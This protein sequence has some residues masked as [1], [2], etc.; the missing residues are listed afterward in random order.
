M[1]HLWGNPKYRYGTYI[2]TIAQLQLNQETKELLSDSLFRFIKN[3]E[4]KNNSTAADYDKKLRRMEIGQGL[5]GEKLKAAFEKMEPE[6][7]N[8]A[9]YYLL[10]L[11][12]EK[13]SITLYGKALIS[14][15]GDGVLYK[16]RR[17]K[18]SLLLYMGREENMTDKAVFAFAGEAFLP[19][20]Y[21]VD[22]YWETSFGVIGEEA[23]MELEAILLY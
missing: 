1:E 5:Y 17:K 20:G 6:Q 15:L 2:D 9:L 4:K 3:C 13:E 14:L 23:C 11:E 22:I 21:T 18:D 8:R 7:Q 19:F 16:N 12:Q 10:L